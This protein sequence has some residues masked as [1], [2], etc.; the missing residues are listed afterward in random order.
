MSR[1]QSQIAT[2]VVLMSAWLMMV[3][4]ARP[5]ESESTV[6]IAVEATQ[7][8]DETERSVPIV[9]V[10]GSGRYTDEVLAALTIRFMSSHDIEETDAIV[11]ALATE[12]DVWRLTESETTSVDVIE[13]G[14]SLDAI[15][16]A[17]DERFLPLDRSMLPNLDAVPDR[18]VHEVNG[19]VPGVDGAV[20]MFAD[21]QSS[22]KPIDWID[23]VDAAESGVSVA[24]PG[25]P[26]TISVVFVFALGSGDP[27]VGLERYRRIVDAGGRAVTTTA[28]LREVM[29]SA[30]TVGAWSSSGVV[31]LSREGPTAAIIAPSS[32]LVPLPAF[33]GIL[34]TADDPVAAHRWL[35]YRLAAETQ[36]VMTFR[37]LLRSQNEATPVPWGPV[38][39]VGE[40]PSSLVGFDPLRSPVLE[41]DWAALRATA[42]QITTELQTIV[43][44]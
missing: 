18:Y 20:V 30:V 9:N 17:F 31:A 25:P 22:Y 27:G 42:D 40:D 8:S 35:N 11:E 14:F 10:V 2:G 12:G 15:S 16:G 29:D 3:L 19:L 26:L 44:Q 34:A 38:V 41:L 4:L 43:D 32:G 6:P 23:L 5:V 1:T 21:G 39:D 28:Q 33:S 7:T 36:S 13:I 37:P 24:V